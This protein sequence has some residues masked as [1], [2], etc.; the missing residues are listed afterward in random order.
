MLNALAAAL[1]A[2]MPMSADSLRMAMV[3]HREYSGRDAAATDDDLYASPGTDSIVKAV[4]RTMNGYGSMDFLTGEKGIERYVS[5]CLYDIDGMLYD[6]QLSPE[7]LESYR[8][9]ANTQHMADA[10]SHIITQIEITR[11]AAL[12]REDE[13]KEYLEQVYE[14][15]VKTQA[16]QDARAAAQG[17]Q[18]TLPGLEDLDEP[19]FLRPR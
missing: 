1:S 14:R 3:F 19:L 10:C 8:K 2:G 9:D 17:E 18:E 13:L 12:D 16:A 6:L 4:K 15:V 11:S 7:L 5:Y